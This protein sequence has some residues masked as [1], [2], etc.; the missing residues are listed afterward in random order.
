MNQ[1]LNI[2]I[3]LIVIINS[4]VVIGK[5]RFFLLEC[6][7]SNTV[8]GPFNRK[9]VWSCKVNEPV[10]SFSTE[11]LVKDKSGANALNMAMNDCKRDVYNRFPNDVN[12]F[13]DSA[14]SRNEGVGGNFEDVYN[15]FLA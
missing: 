11:H 12:H 13:Y 9:W 6:K 4:I 5:E 3:L 7:E 1:F 10:Y 2:F 14:Q 8:G 15:N